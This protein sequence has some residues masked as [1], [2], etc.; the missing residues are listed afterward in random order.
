[1]MT[2]LVVVCSI[3]SLNKIASSLQL[4]ILPTFIIFVALLFIS[5]HHRSTATRV[6][7]SSFLTALEF[8]PLVYQ[9][10]SLQVVTSQ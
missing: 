9:H 6:V 1:M 2:P 4:I 8:R 3:N 7:S 10:A 5:F